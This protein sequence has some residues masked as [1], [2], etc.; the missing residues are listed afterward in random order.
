MFNRTSKGI[1]SSHEIILA[2]LIA[3]ICLGL[4]R[5]SNLPSDMHL[6]IIS[7]DGLAPE[8]YLEA[9]KH[10]LQIPTLRSFIQR[11]VYST[12]METIYPSVTYPAHASLVTGVRPS[13]H[14]IYANSYFYQNE[15]RPSISG[16]LYE[17][18]PFWREMRKQRLTSASVFWPVT[19][20]EPIDWL[21]PCEHIEDLL[22]L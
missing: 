8:Y 22:P 17:A 21:V 12:G 6:V 11:G 9:D 4:V 20:D 3:I 18:E 7:M 1:Q 14:G 13:G 16:K 2:V 19:K 15:K 5:C 10:G